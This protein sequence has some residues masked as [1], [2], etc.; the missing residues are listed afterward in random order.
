MAHNNQTRLNALMWLLMPQNKSNTK[1]KTTQGFQVDF[2]GFYSKIPYILRS[3]RFKK[4]C[5]E[6]YHFESFKCNLFA[7]S[8]NC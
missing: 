1:F 4:T 5:S 6:I 2:D 8:D 7:D 3:F